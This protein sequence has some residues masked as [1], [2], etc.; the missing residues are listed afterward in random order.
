MAEQIVTI[1]SD[2][3]L[4]KVRSEPDH[5]DTMFTVVTGSMGNQDLN[6]HLDDDKQGRRTIRQSLA[7]AQVIDQ[8]PRVKAH[9]RRSIP[10]IEMGLW[11]HSQENGNR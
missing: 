4:K 8:S 5:V 1:G 3:E 10:L 11:R 9:S 7:Q 2:S 6:Y